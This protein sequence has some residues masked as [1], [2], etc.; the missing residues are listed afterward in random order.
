ME[1]LFLKLFRYRERKNRSPEED[2]MTELLAYILKNHTESLLSVLRELKVIKQDVEISNIY[3]D[4]QYIIKGTENTC[5]SRPDIIIRFKDCGK[6]QHFILMEN[7]ID[8]QEGI[9]QLSRYLSY[10]NEQNEKGTMGALIY[11]TKNYDN[12]E[13]I[14]NMSLDTEHQIKFIQ[15]RWW[16][17]YQILK[18]YQEVEII[19]E[20]LK[21]MKEKGLS[22]S[23]KFSEMDVKAFMNVNRIKEMLQ[24]GLGGAVEE[25]YN[26]ITGTRY[27]IT[28]ADAE[29]RNTG[30]Y[31]YMANQKDWFWIGIGYW[32][33]G[34][35]INKEYPDLKVIIGVKPYHE[36][37]DKI[38]KA[39]KD[40]SYSNELWSSFGLEDEESWAGIWRRISLK[41]LLVDDDHIG[42][43]Q[44][45]FLEGLE[46]VEEFKN[47]YP[48]LPWRA[49]N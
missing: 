47:R 44:Q 21:F 46:D 14:R 38:I 45:W 25:K 26:L 49:N 8:S 33:D 30:R 27:S 9:N 48:K 10:L 40:F 12:K 2:F 23:R 11:L 3:V 6:K 34:N 13:Y 42:N 31:I 18:R 28:S 35:L 1:S 29:L 15:I 41:D 5:E 4:T 7:K 19:R 39:F 36:E 37:R 32:V 43:I 20:T 17:L 22:M 24:E 16:Q